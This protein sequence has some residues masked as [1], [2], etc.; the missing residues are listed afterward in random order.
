MR[1]V[2][3]L[4]GQWDFVADLDPKYHAVH[5]GFHKPDANRRH[6]LKVRVPGVWQKYAERYD[7]FEGVCWFA[8]EFDVP[9]LP[10][11]AAAR[12]RFGAVN[13]LCR[14]FL[15][16]REI[17][18]HEGGYTPFSLDAAV[19]LTPGT[20]HI[21]VQVDNRA[22]SIKWPP[23]LGYF[24]Y[25][26]IHRSVT[27][28]I[29]DGPCLDEVAIR[30]VPDPI[31]GRLFVRAA[32]AGARPGL[33]LR[34]ESGGLSWEERV[35]GTGPFEFEVSFPDAGPWSPASPELHQVRVA[36]LEGEAETDGLSLNV[37]FRSIE[38]R[39]GRILLNGRP[40]ALKGV[41]YVYDSPE[42]GLVMTPGQVGAD[43][44]MIKEAGCNAVRCHYP[45]D[46]VFYDACDRLGLLVW[47]EPPIY[48][49]HPGDSETGTRF[50]DPVWLE[51]AIRMAREMVAEAR[52]H[53]CVAIYGIGNECNTRNPEAEPFFR[54]LAAAV[55][56]ADP[57]RLLSYA[58]LYGL[59]GPIA[60]IVDVLGVNSYWGWYDRICGGKGLEPGT[61]DLS[62][63]IGGQS[64]VKKE[65]I[66]LGPMRKMLD[67]VLANRQNL[68]LLL[69]EFG[70]DS[71]SGFRSR[72]R[73]LWSEDYH[74][75]L[76]SAVFSL[77]RDYPQIAGTFPF[78]FN[79][80]RDP[81]KVHN[82]YWNELN[83][84]GMVDYGRNRK[85]AFAA[86]KAV[87]GGGP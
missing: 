75:D 6:W 81:S 63:A 57:T 42:H 64:A 33:K 30:A 25:G 60:N 15:N 82:G 47:I 27:L 4:D 8:R 2:I 44:A 45:M 53:P 51:L 34:V 26:G 3:S 5:G 36:L 84:K 83:L 50:S 43:L 46:P 38:L 71:V 9:A 12:L 73:D 70:A 11:G 79:D 18:G 58:A 1:Q 16:G 72:S 76:L 10:A 40:L 23:C 66:D 74:A 48:C 39:G 54:A 21:A 52:N 32:V 13:Y 55:R 19:A 7:V 61:G 37:G 29:T 35:A 20:N 87:Y 68:A 86:L 31:G 22:T 62:S 56:A 78:C 80:Y 77:A 85:L 41:C 28:E 24:N 65:H 17:G 69:T 14:V 59:V 67:E 49:Y